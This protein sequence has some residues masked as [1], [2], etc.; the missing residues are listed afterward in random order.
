MPVDHMQH[1][2]IHTDDVEG[3]AQWFEKCLGLRRGGNPD[4]KVPLVWLYVGD[5]HAIHIAPFPEEGE[6]QRFQDKY[7]G[8]RRTDVT[9]GSG[10]IDHVAFHCTGLPEMISRLDS[11]GANYLK[12]QAN[13]GDLFQLFIDAPNDIRIELNFAAAEADAAGV[14]PDLSAAEAVAEA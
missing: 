7:L 11:E 2:L 10:V 9:Y 4:F 12:R 13:D 5:V 8:G 1:V 3:T 6:T 14:K